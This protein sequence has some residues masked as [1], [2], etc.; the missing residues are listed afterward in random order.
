MRGWYNIRM[1]L[2]LKLVLGSLVLAAVFLMWRL[3]GSVVAEN[4]T[5]STQEQIAAVGTPSTAASGRRDSDFDGIPDDREARYN[6]DMF[7]SDT[8]GDGYLDGEEVISGYNPTRKDSNRSASAK[9][10]VTDLFTQRLVT[11]IHAGDLN[12]KNKDAKT[13]NTGLDMVSLA[14]ID[15]AGEVLSATKQ[16]SSIRVVPDTEENLSEYSDFLKETIGGE[17]FQFGFYAQD[18]RMKKALENIRN[19]RPEI[20]V[21]TFAMNEKF[22]ASQVA[23]WS[24]QPVPETFKDFH[25]AFLNYLTVMESHYRA[26]GKIISDPLLA[27]MALVAIPELNIKIQH[28]IVDELSKIVARYKPLTPK[29][30]L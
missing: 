3:L 15:D 20:A 16:Q 22:F 7:K 5:S 14:A 28:I 8:D 17:A 21:K 18:F 25:T 4:S 12:P 27:Q 24:S 30:S 1:S 23:Q 6:T 29:A 11:G 19:N 26:A 2:K 10:N 13:Y 9:K